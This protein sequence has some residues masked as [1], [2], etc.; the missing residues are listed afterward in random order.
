MKNSFPTLDQIRE[1]IRNEGKTIIAAFDRDIK[2]L[3]GRI[4]SLED[5]VDKGFAEVNRR[6]DENDDAH[7][8]ILGAINEIADRKIKKH[9]QQY[10]FVA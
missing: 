6:F 7:Q 4:N 1:V 2:L 8:E 9:C 5:K 3:E 10:H